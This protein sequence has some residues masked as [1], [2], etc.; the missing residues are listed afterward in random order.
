M[1]ALQLHKMIGGAYTRTA[2]VLVF[3]VN[4]GL[5]ILEN[6]GLMGVPY[7]EFLKSALEALKKKNEE[8]EK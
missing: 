2:V 5:S 6:I 8:Q 7:P 3:Y 4:E 1:I